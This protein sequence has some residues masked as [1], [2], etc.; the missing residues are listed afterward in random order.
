MRL[1]KVTY[2]ILHSNIVPD[3]FIP[4]SPEYDHC[5][6][7]SAYINGF[8]PVCESLQKEGLIKEWGITGIGEP[9]TVLR[10]ISHSPRPS[11]IEVMYGNCIMYVEL[12]LKNPHSHS[13]STTLLQQIF[14][15]LFASFFFLF[16][17]LSS[18]IF[19]HLSSFIFLEHIYIQYECDGRTGHIE[20]FLGS[21]SVP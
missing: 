21:I 4:P 15:R 11:I 18:F 17:L 6:R 13:S 10:A 1:S 3:N 16:S 9:G 2:L 12:I 8:I 20:T 7:W 19:F 14:F 5:T